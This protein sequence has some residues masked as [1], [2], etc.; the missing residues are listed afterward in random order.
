MKEHQSR[1]T[2]FSNVGG[3]SLDRHPAAAG[4]QL[5][6]ESVNHEEAVDLGRNR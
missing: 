6:E 4:N 2:F 1:K 5:E 3:Q